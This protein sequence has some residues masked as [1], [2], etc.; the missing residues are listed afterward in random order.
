MS[1]VQVHYRP[2]ERRLCQGPFAVAAAKALLSRGH[3]TAS[4]R[5]TV[6]VALTCVHACAW[7]AAGA[8][9]AAVAAERQ[10]RR[11][12]PVPSTAAALHYTTTID[13]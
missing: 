3:R 9:C 12:L 2:P 8:T 11:Q 10:R 6:L 7:N 1:G 5:P 13:R 4:R